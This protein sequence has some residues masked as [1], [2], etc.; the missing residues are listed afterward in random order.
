[1]MVSHLMVLMMDMAI[2]LITVITFL[3]IVVVKVIS[4]AG[5]DAHVSDYNVDVR[6]SDTEIHANSFNG[7]DVAAYFIVVLLGCVFHVY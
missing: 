1:M 7:T 6:V 3:V 5:G 4:K 2:V